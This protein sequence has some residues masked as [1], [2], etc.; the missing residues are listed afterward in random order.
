MATDQL[1]KVPPLY[2]VRTALGMSMQDAAIILNDAD[3]DALQMDDLPSE[4]LSLLSEMVG[5]WGGEVVLCIKN[6]DGAT[7]KEWIVSRDGYLL[8]PKDGD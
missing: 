5:D 3:H 2:A 1:T 6:P 7:F 4:Q 8:E